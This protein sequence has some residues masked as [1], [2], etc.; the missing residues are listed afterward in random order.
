[1]ETVAS[2]NGDGRDSS[3]NSDNSDSGDSSDG[4][5]SNNSDSSI[6]NLEFH[7]SATRCALSGINP[8]TTKILYP[9][10]G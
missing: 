8:Y 5:D 9:C 7:S 10:Y 4:R 6:V 1:M 3:D 2:D